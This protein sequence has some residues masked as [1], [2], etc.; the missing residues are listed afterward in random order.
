MDETGLTLADFFEGWALFEY[1]ALAGAVAGA[2]LGLLGVYVV[3]RRLVF[4]SAAVSQA[5]GLGVVIAFYLHAAFAV[6]KGA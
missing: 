1:P 2:I 3:L 4:L 6:G 5:A